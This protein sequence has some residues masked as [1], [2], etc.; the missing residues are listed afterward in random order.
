MKNLLKEL[1]ENN[2]YI[3]LQGEDIKLKFDNAKPSPELVSKIKEN[4]KDI[5][6]YLKKE[7]NS[8]NNQIVIPK[9]SESDNG[10][11]LSSS[12]MRLWVLS[13]IRESSVA[14]N[15]PFYTISNI[16][17]N[18][19]A[20]EKAITSVVG[21]HEI[22]R[23]VFRVNDNGEVRQWVLPSEE[24]QVQLEFKDL[25]NENDSETRAVSHIEEDYFL[26]FNLVDGPLIRVKLIKI[27]ENKTVFYFN[28]HHIISDAWSMEI[29]TRDTS[30]FYNAYEKDE[31]ISLPE[32]NIQYKDY[33]S[34]QQQ[35][36]NTIAHN[37]NKK[38][39]IEQLKGDLPAF[40]LSSSGER[41][42][43]KTSNGNKYSIY[44]S[45]TQIDRLRAYVTEKEGTLFMGLMAILK[46]LMLKY[47]NQRD[48]IIGTPISGRDHID[49]KDQIGFYVNTLA[50]RS[51]IKE[52]M[53][54]DMFFTLVKKTILDA[55]K[56]Q[57]YP[58][59]A[60]VDDLHLKRDTSRSA[61]FDVMFVHQSPTGDRV[62]LKFPDVFEKEKIEYNTSSKFDLLFNF[63][64]YVDGALLQL[65][66][67]SDIYEA[68]F[69]TQFISHY[70]NLLQ[71]LPNQSEKLIN[72]ISCLTAQDLDTLK[73]FNN[74]GFDVQQK[75][76][77]NLFSEQVSK[78]PES[79]A[80][81]CQNT[82]LTYS[83]L[84]E[85]S[86]QLANLLREEYNISQG[87]MVGVM[88]PRSVDSV[89][90]MIGVVKAGAVYVPI[91]YQYPSQRISYIC[92]DANLAIVIT[93][94]DTDAYISEAE[95]QSVL[96]DENILSKYPSSKSDNSQL[97]SA[98]FVIYT[99]G[100]MGKPKGVVQTHKMLSNLIQWDIHNCRT[101][102]G[103]K[104]LQ[105]ASFSFDVSLQDIFCTLCSS[106]SIYITNEQERFN[107]G[108]LKDVILSKSIEV[109]SFPYSAL[110]NFFQHHSISDFSGHSIKHIVT[111]GEQLYVRGNLKSF[112]EQ[113]PKVLLHNH[114]GP[115]E[116]HV[117]TSHTMSVEKETLAY[118]PSIG[119]P[120]HNSTICILDDDLMP[121]P[122]GVKG[123]VYIG[124]H[125]L[126]KGYLNLTDLTNKRFIIN[127][128]EPQ[129]L[130]YKTGDLGFW[131]K[132]G[133]LEYLG[134]QDK[135]IKI[136]GYRVELEEIATNLIQLE[137]IEEAIVVIKKVLEEE[138]VCAYIVSHDESMDMKEV[139]KGLEAVLP[140]Y[141][142]PNFFIR[143][144]T[145]PLTS[146]GKINKDVLPS[147]L[148]EGII[149][150][151]EY[152]PPRDEMETK[153]VEIWQELLGIKRI[154]INE[155]FFEL[156]GHS[157]KLIKLVNLY[158]KLFNIEI[159][160]KELYVLTT[161]EKHAE[162][163]STYDWLEIQEKKPNKYN[164]TITF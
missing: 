129:E 33:A 140:V 3:S 24:F 143:V 94:K 145:I 156:G 107:Y 142:I 101:D 31:T 157:I 137:E 22:L 89:I 119:K 148:L 121:V 46:V 20:F 15:M 10:Y 23:T 13:Q 117:V 64:E 152:I 71:E 144:D 100:S 58:F 97:D 160:L 155:N 136:R 95:S 57:R 54:F 162:L 80:V 103:L 147:P 17:Y 122:I 25:S 139:R 93:N 63:E 61:I 60:L 134:R 35:Q 83:D 114:Y 92:E 19:P 79:I 75:T 21:R 11:P 131:K 38:Y 91:D 153:L 32:L 7:A 41:P 12:Q 135:Q 87:E 154:G 70:I 98:A 5:I 39:W 124:G 110:V 36:L 42:K 30:M 47:T 56:Y 50:I 126:A 62:E 76:V 9:V 6:K 69:I 74:T 66:Y 73:L 116:T 72:Q 26:P 59:D 141:M 118:R 90:A 18:I 81:L 29:I 132:D 115:S 67:N 16:D 77:V 84:E 48:L 102:V 123:E 51:Q 34:W 125:N 45:N 105:Y 27:A 53:T 108:L 86:N 161:I 159:K 37:A 164:E 88:L 85:K 14:Y 28:I 68:S 55:Y 99:S 82:R 2:V 130:L 106:G 150:Q 133:T 40:E 4:K 109:L 127:P 120:I 65:E 112:L 128:K 146:N 151:E 96:I 138:Y 8:N 158:H 1:R 104:Y 43:V 149:Q 78:T 44:I 52:N 111:S 49:L 163:I 113:Y